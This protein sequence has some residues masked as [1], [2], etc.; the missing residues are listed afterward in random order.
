MFFFS[1][2]GDWE[3]A[4]FA[5]QNSD[6]KGVG[7]HGLHKGLRVEVLSSRELVVLAAN[8]YH[9][10]ELYSEKV[11][12]KNKISMFFCGLISFG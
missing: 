5:A 3:A 2:D 7:H 8:R 6:G 11:A 12:V 1:T 10:D 9:Y 4:F